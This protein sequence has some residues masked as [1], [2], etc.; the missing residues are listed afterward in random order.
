MSASRPSVAVGSLLVATLVGLAVGVGSAIAA[1]PNN[2][3]YVACLTKSSGEVRI[4]DT[5]R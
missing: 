1:I 3:T 2:G 5:P 4:I